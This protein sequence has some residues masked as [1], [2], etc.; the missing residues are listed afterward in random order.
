MWRMCLR[1]QAETR[2]LLICSFTGHRVGAKERM[3][4]TDFH[5][6]FYQTQNLSWPW[7]PPAQTRGQQYS[8]NT[9]TNARLYILSCTTVPWS[10]KKPNSATDCEDENSLGPRSLWSGRPHALQLLQQCP[11]PSTSCVDFRS[12]RVQKM[13]NWRVGNKSQE[14][15]QC[16]LVRL[17]HLFPSPAHVNSVCMTDK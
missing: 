4:C 9:D 17:K 12:C 10:R 13:E 7:L 3:K 14:V 1:T 16:P 15:G 2:A 6:P 11:R 5:D 8:W